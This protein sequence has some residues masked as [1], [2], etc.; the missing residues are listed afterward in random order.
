MPSLLAGRPAS[1]VLVG[2]RLTGKSALLRHIETRALA[3]AE[4]GHPAPWRPLPVRIDCALLDSPQTL[5][6]RLLGALAAGAAEEQGR[7]S[8][9]EFFAGEAHSQQECRR[10][11]AELSSAHRSLLL[12][13][14]NFDQLLARSIKP[15]EFCNE[16]YTL[17]AT[18]GLVI[19]S[20][21]PLYDLN[22]SLAGA[23]LV[24]NSTQLFL[25]LLERTAALQW[26]TFELAEAAD[27]ELAAE[28]LSYSGRH[29]FLLHKLGDCLAELAPLGLTEQATGHALLPFLRLRFA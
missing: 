4:D 10:L 29:P 8:Q 16:L 24:S 6:P 7:C 26:I 3:A 5:W 17:T 22:S 12:L 20:C 1:F 14:D 18:I 9:A 15:A 19:T 25:G 11:I 23:S 28:L 2:A 21:K 13:L 27:S